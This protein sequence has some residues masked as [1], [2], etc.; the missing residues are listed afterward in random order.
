MNAADVVLPR[1]PSVRIHLPNG[2]ERLASVTHGIEY[3]ILCLTD[4]CLRQNKFVHYIGNKI[5]SFESY[6]SVKCLFIQRY[7]I[8]VNDV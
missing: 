2:A 4:F 8:K 3:E 1:N 6:F 7:K 5:A